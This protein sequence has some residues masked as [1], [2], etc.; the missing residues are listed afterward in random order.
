MAISFD[1]YFLI[2]SVHIFYVEETLVDTCINK[3]I[4][5]LVFNKNIESL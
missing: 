2:F 5:D 4:K 3:C 1:T